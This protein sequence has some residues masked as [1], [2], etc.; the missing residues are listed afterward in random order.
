MLGHRYVGVD[1]EFVG[2]DVV[3][4][5]CAL[6]FRSASFDHVITNAV[7]EHVADPQTAVREVS[8]IR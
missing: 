4:N 1:V 6:P 5:A 3:A 7:L 2:A 8:R